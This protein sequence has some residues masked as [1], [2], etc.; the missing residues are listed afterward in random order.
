M[1]DAIFF[2][3]LTNLAL[4]ANIISESKEGINLKLWYTELD[5]DCIAY[6]ASVKPRKD[7]EE[8]VA[9]NFLS[10]PLSIPSLKYGDDRNSDEYMRKVASKVSKGDVV[11]IQTPAYISDEIGL[12]N[13]LHDRGAV[14]VGLV[15]DIEYARGFSPDFSDQYKLLK[16]YDGLVVTG[17]RIKAIIRESGI[18]SIPITCMELWPYLT[19]YVVKHRIEP[20]NNRIEY[21]GNLSRSNGLFSKSLE[22]IEHVDVWG[23]QVDRSNSEKTGLVVQHGAVHP[24]DL[25]ARLYSGYGLVWYVDRKYQDYTKINVSH[26]ASL[27]LSAKLPLI[28]SSSSYLSELVDKYKIGICVD[29]LDEIPEKLL[30]RNDY[31][32][33]VNNIEEYIYDSISSGSCFTEPFVDLMSKLEVL[34]SSL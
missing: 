26:K 19:N 28:V 5:S 10:F 32:K 2:I 8:I 21:A 34:E 31:C 6:D 14:V 22:G 11:L 33:Y 25:P 18:S 7:I 1:A 12:V 17:H 3:Y 15:H 30:S 23:K 27:Y 20:N 9:I 29:R 4:R 24:D 16:L 13:K